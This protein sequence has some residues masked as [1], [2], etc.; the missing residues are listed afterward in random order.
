MIFCA[1]ALA[2]IPSYSMILSQLASTQGSGMYRIEQQVDF[3]HSAKPVS[4][5]ETWWVAKEGKR[6]TLL[7]L[8][9]RS[10]PAKK[11]DLYLRFIYRG[12]YKIFKDEVGK[13]RRQKISLYHIDKPFHL[14]DVEKLGRLFY[15]WKFTP[16]FSPKDL[17]H[18]SVSYK[19]SSGLKKESLATRL[20]HP[21]VSWIQLARRQGVVHYR[22]A[23]GLSNKQE[24]LWL[25]Q[26]EFV[27]RRW[28]WKK[29]SA[30]AGGELIA[31]D[32]RAYPG[33]LFFPSQR[34]LRWNGRQV[35]IKVRSIKKLP[36]KWNLFKTLHLIKRN[37]LS[38]H[39]LPLDR[40]SMKEF[41]QKF[42]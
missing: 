41:Y 6:G 16:F 17:A 20:S 9:V 26:D 38:S 32:Y 18:S 13:R 19:V 23:K 34:R 10:F 8:D 36:V 31:W 37:T 25:E 33:S 24:G 29:S 12:L 27:I 2:Y 1:K 39:L 15:L 42:R 22:L 5:I 11:K 40:D 4:V 30:S 28:Q 7:R 35:S 3:K 21:L 14:R